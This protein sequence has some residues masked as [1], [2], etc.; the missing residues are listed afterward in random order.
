MRNISGVI[1]TVIVLGA[2]SLLGLGIFNSQQPDTGSFIPG[3]GGGP[4]ETDLLSEIVKNPDSYLGRTVTVSGEVARV[5]SPRMFVLDREGTVLGDELL[6][7][8]TKPLTPQA[9]RDIANPFQDADKVTVTGTVRR[10][11]ITDIERDIGM[12][13]ETEIEVEY[14]NE[15]VIAATDVNQVIAE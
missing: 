7:Y 13:L 15:P 9:G 4:E 8:T 1:V 5:I 11:V 12:D 14:Q 10:F 3:V 6:I 2:L